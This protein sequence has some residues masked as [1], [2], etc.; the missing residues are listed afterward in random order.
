MDQIRSLPAAAD[1]KFEQLETFY[2]SLLQIFAE[3]QDRGLFGDFDN[4]QNISAIVR[5][6]PP[7]ELDKWLTRELEGEGEGMDDLWNFI[8]ARHRIV[9]RLADEKKGA[10]KGKERVEQKDG[11]GGKGRELYRVSA[12]AGAV[13]PAVGTP[14]ISN[15]PP[16]T[17]QKQNNNQNKQTFEKKA[18]LIPGCTYKTSHARHTCWTWNQMDLGTRVDIALGKGWCFKCLS[19][20]HAKPE[21]CNFTKNGRVCSQCGSPD[22]TGTLCVPEANGKVG[23]LAAV[24]IGEEMEVGENRW[25]LEPPL[26]EGP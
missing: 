18:C 12:N 11:K 3:V 1:L 26:T 4:Q 7:T 25:N 17:P 5:C 20:N 19:K 13:A 8:T 23:M 10:Q 22:H 16:T 21:D 6:L 15:T 24:T 9:A 14:L 2:C